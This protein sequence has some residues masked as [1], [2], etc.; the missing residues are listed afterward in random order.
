MLL[1]GSDLIG[2]PILSLHMGREIARVTELIIDPESLKIV[3]F[4]ASG[5]EDGDI[6]TTDDIREFSN[7]GMI[8]DSGD[9]FA[10]QGDVVRVDKISELRFDIIGLNVVTKKGTKLGKASN[11]MV[12]TNDFTVQ[13]IV[14][15]RPFF[16]A[17]NDPELWV[18]RS[19]IVEINDTQI[20]VKDEEAKI[21]QKVVED[22]TSDFV[23]PF[24]KQPALQAQKKIPDELD[25]E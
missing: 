17:F 22:F 23:N 3:A 11:Y 21:K 18:G 15:Q 9:V 24:R 8:V 14:V 4:R 6:L 13:Q 7:I 19:E 16:K 25:T 10:N 2:Y 12:N 20:I 5:Y 1:L